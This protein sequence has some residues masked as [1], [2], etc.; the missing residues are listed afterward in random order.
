MSIPPQLI[1]IKRKR[2]D[3]VP[4]TFLQFD[5]AH[6]RHRINSNWAY[7][8]RDAPSS[9]DAKLSVPSEKPVI[10]ISQPGKG[11]KASPARRSAP[12][13]PSSPAGS[14]EPRR[15]HISRPVSSATKHP[16]LRAGVSKHPAGA[17]PAVFVERGQ[18]RVRRGK[19][20]AS[21]SNDG[22]DVDCGQEQAAPS[23]VKRRDLKPAGPANKAGHCSE[24]PRTHAP[25]PASLMNRDAHDMDRIADDMNKWVLDEIGANLKSQEEERREPKFKPKA[26]A[27]RYHE[28]HPEEK[29][30]VMDDGSD[31]D[32]GDDDSDWIMEEYVR[33]PANSVAVGV[34]PW[35]IGVLV[36]DEEYENTLFFGS[37]DDDE[38]EAEDD[39]NENAENH[40]TADYPEDEVESDDEY[41]IRPYGYRN[42]GASDDEEFDQVRCSDDDDD[43]GDG[44]DVVLDSEDDD[45]AKMER[46]RAYMKHQRSALS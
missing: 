20:P 26:P 40:Y 1:R 39:E 38:E 10:H 11:G 16:A 32:D 29:D 35:D 13:L 9:T 3:E 8:R 27:Q 41:N 4:V 6:K 12:S 45:E 37:L 15:F 24:G 5:E 33:I 36:L 18:K 14:A 22:M 30:L 21:S 25:L 28:R 43:D 2:D 19:K 46:I 31:G 44:D 42:L 34:L 17:G 23:E 7:R